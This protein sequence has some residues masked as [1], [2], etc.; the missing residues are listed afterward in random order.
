MKFFFSGRLDQHYDEE[1][2]I[3]FIMNF[4]NE[5]DF[6]DTVMTFEDRTKAG[7]Q[8]KPHFHFVVKF[9]TKPILSNPNWE[10]DDEIPAYKC[11]RKEP[12][13]DTIRRWMSAYDKELTKTFSSLKKTDDYDK[14]LVYMLKNYHVYKY[15]PFSDLDEDE[16]NRY[17]EMSANYQDTLEIN[18][19]AEHLE[20]IT[21]Q[22]RQQTNFKRTF[23]GKFIIN[24][25]LDWN[26]KHEKKSQKIKRPKDIKLWIKQI[27]FDIL[28]VE[29]NM[30]REY[31]DNMAFYM[32]TDSSPFRECYDADFNYIK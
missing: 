8:C 18:T 20:E 12:K 29:E 23:M 26:E 5:F 7:L 16:L 31:N 6:E 13:H 15:V 30:S 2:Y 25:I 10:L 14:A 17:I 3:D 19:T 1:W 27:E 32:A 11:T 24:Y 4:K 21:K 9:D 28:D 22:L